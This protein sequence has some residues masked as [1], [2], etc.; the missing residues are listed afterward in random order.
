MKSVMESYSNQSETRIFEQ[1]FI[2]KTHIEWFN[3]K[4][5]EWT[6]KSRIS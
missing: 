5:G 2:N 4:T 3:R 1:E 6:H